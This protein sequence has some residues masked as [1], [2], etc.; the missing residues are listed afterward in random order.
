MADVKTRG[1]DLRVDEPRS[2]GGTETGPTPYDYLAASL[3]S[4][5]SLTLRMYAERKGMRLD[6]VSTAVTFDRVH[7]DDCREC[8]HET[9]RIERFDR[10]VTLAGDL[11]EDDRSRLLTIANRCPVHNTL[12]GQIEVHTTLAV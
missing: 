7:A 2:A 1:F 4:C 11:T 12:E 9:G 5:T 6:E 10:T 3:A 8:E